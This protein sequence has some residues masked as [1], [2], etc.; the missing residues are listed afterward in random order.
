MC[1]QQGNVS[2]EGRAG[3]YANDFLLRVSQLK[4]SQPAPSPCLLRFEQGSFGFPWFLP[5]TPNRSE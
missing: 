5:H 4:N 3:P 2:G 1:A